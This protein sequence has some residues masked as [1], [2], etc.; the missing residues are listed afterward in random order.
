M[1]RT[2]LARTTH[3]SALFLVASLSACRM[4]P[5]P[6]GLPRGPVC[7]AY[8]A[9]KQEMRCPSDPNA[10]TGDACSCTDTRTGVAFRGR[11]HGGL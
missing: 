6:S 9:E 1:N 8:D 7:V 11:V 5:E 4:A 3:R 10:Y 2:A